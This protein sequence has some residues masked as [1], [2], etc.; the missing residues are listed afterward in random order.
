[1]KIWHGLLARMDVGRF[2]NS[3]VE[4]S[5]SESWGTVFTRGGYLV[6]SWGNRDFRAQTA[7]MGKAFT[8]AVLGLAVER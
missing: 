2:Q 5:G 7:S 8:W 1:M 6:H 3:D 4:V